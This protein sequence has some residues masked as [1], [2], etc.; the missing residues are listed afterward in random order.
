[1]SIVIPP[2]F[3]QFI[4]RELAAGRYGSEQEVVAEGLRLL[5]KR[6]KQLSDHRK[7]VDIGLKQLDSGQVIELEGDEAL[8]AFFEDVKTRGRQRLEEQHRAK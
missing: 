2:E 6:E 8:H 7:E 3:E 1:M 5:E 4:A